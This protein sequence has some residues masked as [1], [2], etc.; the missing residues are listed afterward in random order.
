MA[1]LSNKERVGR[2]L[3]LVAEGLQ[4]WMVDLLTR[5]YGETWQA[6]V[7]QAAGQGRAAEDSPDD[8]SYLFWVFDKQWH[9]L[10]KEHADYADKRAVSSLW[11]ARKSWAHGGKFTDDQTERVLGDAEAL[12]RAVGGVMQADQVSK[13]RTDLRRLRYEKDQ[14]R[15]VEEIQ[16][17]LAVALNSAGLPAWR[18]IVEPHDDVAQGTYQL[19]EFAADLRQVHLGVARPEYADP[20]QFYNRTFLTRGL[21]YL[22]TQTVLR[23]NGQ[24]GEPVIDLMTTFGGGKTHS[25]IA[26]YHLAS[27]TPLDRLAGIGELCE[28]AG[29]PGIPATVNRA[30]IVGNDLSI[31]GSTKDDGTVVRTMWGELAWQLGGR[32]GYDM[33]ARYDEQSAPPPTSDIAALLEA[34]SPC[35]VLVDEWVAYMRQLYSRSGDTPVAAG[36]FEDHQTFAQSLTEAFKQVNTAILVV[37]LPASDS[38]R[39]MGKGLSENLYEIGGTPGLESLRSLRSVVHRVE[40]SWQPATVEESFEI[41]RRRIFKP[42]SPDKEAARNLV[43]GKFIDHYEQHRGHV[44]S[45]ALQPG[46]RQT[47]KASYPIHPELFDRLYQDWSTLERFQR[48]RGV[49]RLMA[50]VVHALWV[51]GDTSPLIL[52]ASVP[53]DDTK[54]FEE[55]TSHLDDPW[56]PVVDTD[57]AGP[58][59]TATTIDREISVL[60]RSMATQRAARCVFIGTAPAVNR[61]ARQGDSGPVRGI[62]QKRVVLGATYPGDN[63][64][65]IG[66][67][68]RQLGDRGAYMNR[69]QDRYWLS[70]QQTVSRI[71]HDRAEAYDISEIHA[72]LTRRLREEVDTGVFKRVHRAPATTA[73]VEDEPTAGL[74]VFGMDRPHS[75]KANSTAEAAAREFLASRGAQQRIHKNTLVFLSPDLAQI[76]T[77]DAV[78]RQH[79]AWQSIRDNAQQLNLD[80]HNLGVVTTRVSQADQAVRDTIKAT[81]KWILVPNQEP[82]RPGIEM[83]TIPM[84][85]DGTLAARV[86]KKAAN[87]EFVVEQYAP[88]LLRA[89]IDA[90]KLWK[91]QPHIAVETLAGYF[92]DYLYMPRVQSQQT[93]CDSVGRL[94]EVLHKEQ[95][96]FAYADSYD[97]DAKRY[98]GLTLDDSPARVSTN[99]LVVDPLIARKQLDDEAQ[100]APDPEPGPNPPGKVDPDGKGQPGGGGTPPVPPPPMPPLPPPAPS[101]SRFHATKELNTT[102]VVRDMSQIAEEILGLLTS[103]GITVKVTVDL[104]SQDLAALPND[105]VD[106]LRE[107]LNTLGFTDWNVE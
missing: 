9:S 14:R 94:S 76:D 63:P 25:E 10:F 82:G 77:L 30:V 69:D 31:L 90:L 35:V 39:D 13:M 15:Q 33:L 106:A 7:R 32:A 43:V 47:M 65:H 104:E 70:L 8:P 78:I 102:R 40:A 54:V 86:T 50:T 6:K 100:P 61:N 20:E 53:L 95:D 1:S 92:A 64:A 28:K 23:M 74:V 89:R 37:S 81:Y 27:G 99:G 55:I 46:Y 101:V 75:R 98:R 62:A 19:A 85:G 58:N 44:A 3:D 34:F 17:G 48:T 97:E 29:V 71:V 38:V 45:E 73:D 11:D 59:S 93:V 91:D 88:S 16:K 41:V 60:G 49:L 72:E 103:N 21:Q 84:N 87:S 68:L 4:P 57:I 83:E 105:Q 51:K 18:D 80:Q 12:L 67:A 52:P 107:N 5:K 79:L 2:A 22:L 26:V 66:D 96:G 36:T 24:G 56:K 42:L